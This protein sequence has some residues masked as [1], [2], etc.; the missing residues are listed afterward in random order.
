M[1]DLTCPVPVKQTRD[2]PSVVI[3]LL[4]DARPA[5]SVTSGARSPCRLRSDVK[6][7]EQC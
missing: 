7:R 1:S 2:S 3:A 4:I 5:V 6:T